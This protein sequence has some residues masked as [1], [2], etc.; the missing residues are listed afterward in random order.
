[1]L[2]RTAW[3]PTAL[4]VL[5]T[6]PSSPVFAQATKAGV[7]TALEGSVTVTRAATRQSAPLK[8]KDDV[9]LEDKITAGNRSIARLLLGGKA[10]VT[11]REL[12]TLTIR[13]TPGQATVELES[14]KIA[15]AVARDQMRS[16]ETITIRTA[17]AVGAVRG[18]V[19]VA[20]VV[21]QSAQVGPAL[22]AVVTNFYV[23][24][25]TFLAASFNPLTRVAGTPVPVNVLQGF[26]AA[27]AA[28]PRVAP[29]TQAQLAGITSGLRP[30]APQ[31]KEGGASKD[32]VKVQSMQTA[33]ALL[34]AMF[35]PPP[36]ATTPT[37]PAGPP[38]VLGEGTATGPPA[39]AAAAAAMF[40]AFTGGTG[41]EAFTAVFGLPPG[42]E[43]AI[44]PGT[45]PGITGPIPG[46]TGIPIFGPAPGILGTF[47]P[48]PGGFTLPSLPGL[49][50][51]GFVPGTGPPTP[52]GTT[53]TTAFTPPPVTLAGLPT[54][55]FAPTAFTTVPGTTTFFTPTTAS[56][57]LPLFLQT[58]LST[59]STAPN[60]LTNGGFELGG[61]LTPWTLT[62]AG[63][64]FG[65]GSRPINPP[66]GAFMFVGHTGVV[67]GGSNVT[68]T[69]LTQGFN[70]ASVLSIS[71][72]YVLLTRELNCSGS[73][74]SF[75]RDTGSTAQNDIWQVKVLPS[76]GSPV[77]IFERTASGNRAAF[78][79]VGT[80]FGFDT[81]G[82]GSNDFELKANSGQ[83]RNVSGGDFT[84]LPSTQAVVNPGSVSLE[85]SVTDVGDSDGDSGG[86]LDLV[87]VTQD[88]PLYF[89]RDG[90]PFVR[91]DPAPLLQLTNSPRTF[92]SLMVVCC[93]SSATL[94]GPL[95]R[96]TNSDLTVPFSLLSVIQGGKL[97]T[98]SQE[99]LTFLE[100]GT[101]ALGTS[102]GVFDIAGVNVGADA[103]TG[104]TLGIDRPLQHAGILLET[105]GASVATEKVLKL[106]TALLEATA[107]L[108]NLLA[109]SSLTT[110]TSAV[111][112][113]YRAKVTSLGPLV[114]LDASSLTVRSGALVNVAN[115]SLLNVNGNLV[116]LSNGGILNLRNGPLLSVSGGS[117][118]NV[119]GGLVGFGGSGGN[120][121]NIT[122]SFCNGGC[123]N[124]GGVPVA[125]TNGATAANVS[126]TS[127]VK[128]AS[129]G[130]INLASPNTAVVVVSGSTSKVT[131]SGK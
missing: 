51:G 38:I 67:T 28:A 27:G 105:A 111:D 94:A 65:F 25:G 71:F 76:S 53:P 84:I 102:V 97:V 114:K 101:H 112:L 15:L 64:V 78:S 129:L 92:D 68:Q 50:T 82:D 21:R 39:T 125:L 32:A 59:T 42:A 45:A 90:A 36:G 89:L 12:S 34:T 20:E 103:E 100:G 13:Q 115:G 88:P 69:T 43:G 41:A 116:Q 7:V 30:T 6:V 19:V 74:C 79:P 17:N 81:N 35:G 40:G 95:L 86:V 60:L 4:L 55:T 96:A 127:P 108:I 37:G 56:L 31:Y 44:A 10:I 52:F 73:S 11:V 98:S 106:D 122:N 107:P 29:I 2:R 113:S 54:F 23:L 121:I 63:K 93:N 24:R 80:S 14:G 128:N 26:S 99:P 1:M 58:F 118:L 77:T 123:Y 62:G 124:A 22:P 87:V 109:G 119:S 83:T 8:F 9:F 5:T 33:T 3:I 46:T 72:R 130:S 131:I 61:T 126:I 120:S 117:I 85:F 16:G 49:A 110:N 75:L 57:F 18:T 70:V 48:P 47:T 91:T 66:E 104:L